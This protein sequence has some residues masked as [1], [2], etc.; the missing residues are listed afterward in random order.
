MIAQSVL[1]LSRYFLG[2]LFVSTAIG[3]LLD[4]RGFA[5]VIDTYQLGVPDV[6]LMGIALSVSLLE[7]L[8]GINILRGR[9]LSMN[10]LATLGFHLGYAGLAFATLLRGIALS[11]CGCFGVFLARS[12][13]WSTVGEDLVLAGISLTCWL[14]LRKR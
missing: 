13:T 8:I 14:L 6:A 11:N 3:K 4:N 10:V 2:L 12:L 9:A 1:L 7:L 5:H